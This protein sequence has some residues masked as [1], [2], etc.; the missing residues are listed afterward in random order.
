MA[1]VMKLCTISGDDIECHENEL[2]VLIRALSTYIEP[3]PEPFPSSIFRLRE[4]GTLSNWQDS[5]VHSKPQRYS[6]HKASNNV[7]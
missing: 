1:Q 2:A 7:T 4:Q 3:K 6:K 5:P